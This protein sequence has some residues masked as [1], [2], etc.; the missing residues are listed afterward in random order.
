MKA[1]ETNKA[2][3]LRIRKVQIPLE[4]SV[5]T[6]KFQLSKIINKLNIF[7]YNIESG[8]LR[9]WGLDPKYP[10]LDSLRE[11]LHECCANSKTYDYKIDY[12]GPLLDR[13]PSQYL[14]EINPELKDPLI[15]EINQPGKFWTFYN[16]FVKAC[17]KC[18]FC[19]KID[20]LDDE[21]MCGK[22]NY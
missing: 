4:T 13:E 3:P 7:K 8:S 19:G 1:L 5:K 9:I 11:Y 20:F 22:V 14:E 10:S 21:C 12:N 2:E 15:I 16:E 6:F 17:E 18:D